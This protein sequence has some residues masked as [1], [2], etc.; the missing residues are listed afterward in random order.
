[1]DWAAVTARALALACLYQAAGAALFVA[2]FGGRTRS[3]RARGLGRVAALCALLLVPVQIPL[4]AARMA[5]EISGSIDPALLQL[6]WHSRLGWTI[7]AQMAGLALLLGALRPQSVGGRARD[8]NWIER[9]WLLA[10]AL[11]TAGALTLSGHTSVNPRRVLL[12]P[13]LGLHLL[14]VAFWFGALWPLRMAVVQELPG[15]AKV[16]LQRFS[17]P[18]GILVPGIALAGLALALVLIQ[19]FAVLRRPY[20]LLLLVKLGLF[21][22]LM[23]LAI[24]NRWRYTPSLTSTP[25]TAR[26]A[27]QRSIAAEYWLL[28]AAFAVTA[29]LTTLFS[30]ED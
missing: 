14:I 25:Q 22:V 13:L 15:T 5:G 3:E 12:A 23:V 28:V 24:L 30:P 6:A 11:L 27:L 8:A 20:G 19:D 2:L 21:G 17:R 10:A 18:A 26:R 9:L 1:L 7:A 4:M 29:T 16:L